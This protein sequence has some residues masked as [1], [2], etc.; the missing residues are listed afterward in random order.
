MGFTQ[1]DLDKYADVMIWALENAR[2]DNGKGHM[3]PGDF[4]RIIYDLEAINLIEP[5]YER[6]VKK[7]WNVLAEGKMTPV[8]ERAFYKNANDDQLSFFPP[9]MAPHPDENGIRSIVGNTIAENMRGYIYIFAPTDLHHLEDVDPKR[10]AEHALTMKPFRDWLDETE[11]KGDFGWALGLYPTHALADEAGI[12][13]SEYFEEVKKATYIDLDDPVGEWQKLYDYCQK[14]KQWLTDLDIDHLWV[15]SDNIHLKVVMGEYRKWLGVSGHNI[16]SYETF[17][18]PD[19]RGTEGLYYADK[20]SLKDGNIVEGIRLEFK[21]GKVI[22]ASAKIGEKYLLEM[23]D[24]DPGARYLGEFSLTDRRFSKITRYMAHTM[25]DENVGGEYGNCHIALGR[26]FESM[27]Y[28]GEEEMTPE[29]KNKLGFND[30]A[31]HWDLINGEKKSVTAVLKDGSQI[32][33]YKD[34]Q[35]TLE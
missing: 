31:L 13:L 3:E 6:C 5:I 20:K 15:F 27:L 21:E 14:V 25:Y 22:E 4:V 35:F 32:I 12:S 24:M 9:W 16:P 28:T 30:S 17:T 33:I 19:F 18:T 7:G 2:Q 8:M 34:G 29:L 1:E 10:L 11:S 23:L 26:G